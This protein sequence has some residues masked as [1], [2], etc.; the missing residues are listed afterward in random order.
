M[1]NE[2]EIRAHCSWCFHKTKHKKIETNK[3]GR[4]VFECGKCGQRTLVCM[5]LSCYEMARGEGKVDDVFCA[6][7][8][9]EIAGFDNL[10]MKL[11]AISANLA[12][13]YG[14]KKPLRGGGVLFFM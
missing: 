12:P 13:F 4:A 10:T 7:H 6:A 2:A 8:A 1:N 5:A 11:D 3:L 14:N 9:G